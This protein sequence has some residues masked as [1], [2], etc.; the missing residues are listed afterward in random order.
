MKKTR[1]SLK[2]NIPDDGS[3]AAKINRKLNPGEAN[4]PFFFL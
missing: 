2:E 4:K 3:I 1:F